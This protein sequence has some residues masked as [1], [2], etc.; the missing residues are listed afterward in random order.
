MNFTNEVKL[1]K[2][3]NLSRQSNQQLKLRAGTIK[4]NKIGLNRWFDID[5]VEFYRIFLDVKFD[6]D[7]V[8]FSGGFGKHDPGRTWAHALVNG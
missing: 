7:S 5:S 3:Q 4:I 1:I 8:G 6:F 2:I